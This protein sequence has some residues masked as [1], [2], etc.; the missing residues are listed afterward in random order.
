MQA[1]RTPTSGAE[2]IS[3]RSMSDPLAWRDVPDT[4]AARVMRQALESNLGGAQLPSFYGVTSGIVNR[5]ILN[6]PNPYDETMG[7]ISQRVSAATHSLLLQTYILKADSEAARELFEAVAHR[8]ES[9][10][11]FRCV[12]V[13]NS[14]S[15]SSKKRL[16]QLAHSCGAKI[17]LVPYE[18]GW[19]RRSLH[20]KVAI[21]DGQSAII[22]GSNVDNPAETDIALELSGS[23][24]KS[25]VIEFITLIRDVRSNAVARGA[26]K[27]ATA[28]EALEGKMLKELPQP[29]PAPESPM[30]VLTKPGNSWRGAYYDQV[31]NAALFDAIRNAKHEICVRSPNVNDV[32]L[33]TALAEAAS[34][35]VTVNILLPKGYLAYQS[36]ID[37]AGNYAPLIFKAHRVEKE[38][39]HRF[40]IRWYSD[41]GKT[42]SPSH[43]K[44]FLIDGV[45]IVGSQN[46]DNQSFC[47][48][49][50]LSVAV[51]S[52]TD[53]QKIRTALFDEP[54]AKGLDAPVHFMHHILPIP[55]SS[56]QRRITRIVNMPELIWRNWRA[57]VRRGSTTAPS[58]ES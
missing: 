30:L 22:G 42:P 53:V 14:L 34:R 35:G 12:I 55:E 3:F 21:V 52:P 4:S 58:K 40:T 29:P 46:A 33:L 5:V 13:F 54:W 31:A 11:L 8:Q 36:F 15:S 49:R 38:H 26:I 51:C 45:S 23:V 28:I 27:R 39:A 7:A 37:C 20:S 1:S 9:A 43:A 56:W 10:P 48:S 25:L 47:F 44:L 41:D 57:F 32:H 19:S 50:E 6:T 18:Q 17:D 24:V 16:Q 2:S